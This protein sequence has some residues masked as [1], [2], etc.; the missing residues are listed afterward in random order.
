MN[1][2]DAPRLKA[3]R[4]TRVES[5]AQGLL[6]GD[7]SDAFL[8][9]DS[10]VVNS[11]AVQELIDGMPGAAR[12]VVSG[13]GTGADAQALAGDLAGR[14]QLV[15]VGGGAVLDRAKTATLVAGGCSPA[16]WEEGAAHLDL[17]IHEA[18]VE[19]TAVPT[20]L[21]TGSERN[22]NAV[23]GMATGRV[24]ISAPAIRPTLAIVDPA[25]TRTLGPER[26]RA[27]IYEAVL[28]CLGPSV[29]C[30]STVPGTEEMVLAVMTRLVTLGRGALSPGPASDG[31]RAEIASLS[32]L[33]HGEQMHAGR[34][35]RAFLGWYLAH[36]VSELTGLTK[37]EAL[38]A[39]MPTWFEAV[40]IEDP[41]LGGSAHLTR[42]WEAVA[43]STGLPEDPI[44][45]VRTLAEELEVRVPVSSL[46][47]G[48]LAE[49]LVQRWGPLVP[50][51][52]AGRSQQ[53]R[54]LSEGVVQELALSG[55]LV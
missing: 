48:Q 22:A 49:R 34:H 43:R 37:V 47:P 33:G 4:R 26:T 31:P 17:P 51:L 54:G 53:V 45:G 5:T 14:S 46:D 15:A 38:A 1:G 29:G 36:E 23:V 35:R 27:G 32:A 24:L 44:R 42:L 13:P 9:L 50:A 8:L 30:P 10:G 55:A 40:L 21:G 18:T 12:R 3:S 19:L 28:R 6:A 41:A 7:A 52:A 20:T 11:E 39:V 16:T 25:M 2:H